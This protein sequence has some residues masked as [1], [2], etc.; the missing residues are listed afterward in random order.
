MIV[1]PKSMEGKKPQSLALASHDCPRFTCPVCSLT[2]GA[3]V[4]ST[5]LVT[6]VTTCILI[7][8]DAWSHGKLQE[9]ESRTHEKNV[10]GCHHDDDN[11]LRQNITISPDP[12]WWSC[13]SLFSR[14]TRATMGCAFLFCVEGQ[15]MHCKQ[16]WRRESAALQLDARHQCY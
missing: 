10:Q 3:R 2:Q 14:A 6:S 11:F 13:W 16:P 1:A 9:A 15:A 12:A 5:I 8:K 7:I 4:A